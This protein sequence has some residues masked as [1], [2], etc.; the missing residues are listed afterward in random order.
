MRVL[1]PLPSRDFDPSEVA[2]PW[3]LLSGEAHQVAFATP[4]GRPASA[5]PLMLSGEGL[6]LWARIPGLRQF[7]LLGLLLRANAEARRAH[8]QMLDD[9]A[10]LNPNKY[11]EL[12][13]ADYDALLLPGGHWSRGMRQYLEDSQLQE[14][15]AAFFEADKPVAAICHGVVLAA[16]SVSRLTGK[17]VLFGR[18]TTALTWRLE[19]SAWSAMKFLGRVWDPNYYRTYM[20][21]AGEPV[22]YRSVQAEVTRALASPA[23]FCDV[24]ENSPHH[25][26]KASGM[27]RD[28][29]EDERPCWLVRDG[30]YVSARWPGDVHGFVKVFAAM[31]AV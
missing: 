20:E 8:R 30:R 29:I 3:K 18:K 1:I 19:K 28:S 4:D 11:S 14:F 25:F 7:K 24:P 22:G 6:D 21:A 15:V 10:F 13:V 12:S 31:L 5:D 17:S 26:R 27:F 23:D 2:V 9:S 16:R